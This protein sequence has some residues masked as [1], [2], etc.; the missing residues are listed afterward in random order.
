VIKNGKIIDVFNSEIIENDIAIVDGYIAGIGRYKGKEEIDANGSYISPGLIDGHVHV[1]SSMVTPE[2]F[3]KVLLMRGVTTAITDPHEI[4][5]VSGIDGIKYILNQ[6]DNSILDLFVML[7]S[8]VPATDFESD[9]FSGT[10][11]PPARPFSCARPLFGQVGSSSVTVFMYTTSFRARWLLQRDR[12][13]VHDLFS[14]TL[15]SPA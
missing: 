11:A 9:L 1:E 6:S 3:A 4:A 2:E 14:G 5:N 13:H 7:P 10:L 15:D 12:F 8:C